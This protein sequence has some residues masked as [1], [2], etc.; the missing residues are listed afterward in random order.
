M[1]KHIQKRANCGFIVPLALFA[2]DLDGSLLDLVGAMVAILRLLT[3]KLTFFLL[4]LFEHFHHICIQLYCNQ[5][6]SSIV[7]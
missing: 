5:T 6:I 4:V 3:N 7:V 1:L 2:A